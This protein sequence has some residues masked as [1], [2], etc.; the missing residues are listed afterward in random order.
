M[1]VERDGYLADKSVTPYPLSG[2]TYV[3]AEEFLTHDGDVE[4]VDGVRFVCGE[5]LDVEW[6]GEGCGEPFYL[7][8]VRFEAGV[9]VEPVPE[10]EHVRL[11]G[12]GPRRPAGPEGPGGPPGPG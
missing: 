4:S 3:P 8:F 12:V 6:D 10:S 11:A 1:A 2:W 5:S 7:S 9:E